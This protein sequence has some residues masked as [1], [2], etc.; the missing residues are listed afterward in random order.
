MSSAA[1]PRPVRLLDNPDLLRERLRAA[2]DS[3][4]VYLM[5]DLEAR[6]A[7]VGK[8]ASLR[9]RLRSYFTGVDSHP[10]RTRQLVT[11]VFDFETI[12][13][14]SEREALILETPRIKQ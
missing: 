14:Q 4:G 9:N 7:Y 3:P 12:A 8:A 6:V 11:R 13:C 10:L 2:A 1:P 5:R